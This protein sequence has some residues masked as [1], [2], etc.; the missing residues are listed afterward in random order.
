V[1]VRHN[2]QV[3]L[4][5]LAAAVTGACRGAPRSPFATA[6]SLRLERRS[7]QAVELYRALRD[8]FARTRDTGSLWQ[9]ERYYGDQ[10][11]RLGKDDSA[12][13]SFARALALAGSD[14][15]RQG[16]THVTIEIFLDRKGRLDTA[17]V[18]A[19]RAMGLARAAHDRALEASAYNSLGRIYSYSGRYGDALLANDS[20]LALRRETHAA[21]FGIANALNEL[22]IDYRHLGRYEDAEQV[23]REALATYRRLKNPGQQALVLGNLSNILEATGDLDGSLAA[24]LESMA[25]SDSIRDMRGQ[26]LAR[27]NLA[28]MYAAMGE[29]AKARDYAVQALAVNRAG[30][31]AYGTIISLQNLGGVELALGKPRAAADTERVGLRLADSLGFARERA[32][33]RAGLARALAALGDGRA[34]LR[35]ADEAV[36]LAD[37]LADPEIQYEARAAKSVAARAA[38]LSSRAIAAP[39][40]EAIALLESV[41]GRLALGDLRMGVLEPRREVYEAAIRTMVEDHRPVDAFA[42]AERARARLL[43][44][45]MSEREAA[46]ALRSREDTLR[47]A[48]RDAYDRLGGATARQATEV[49]DEIDRLTAALAATEDAARREGPDGAVRYPTPAVAG[50]VAPLVGS[51]SALLTFF[52]GDSAVYGW[53]IDAHGARAARL[54]SADSLGALV[55]FLRSAI[56]RADSGLDWRLA[57]VHAYQRLIAPL[58]PAAPGTLYVV[59][60]G[61]LAYIPLEVL[62]PAVDSAPWGATRRIVYG[63]SAGVLLALSRRSAPPA[64]PRAVL[65]VGNPA[66]PGLAGPSGATRG[67]VGGASALA[68]LPYA[69]LEARTVYDMFKSDA[70]DL[71]LGRRATRDGWLE[72]EPGR[73]RYLHFAT[74]ARIDERRPDRTA[75]AL[76]DQPLD[77]AAIRRTHLNAALVTL[78]GCETALGRRVRGEGVVGL[79]HAFLAAGARGAVVTLWRIGDRSAADFMED[80]Y[81]ALRAGRRPADALTAVRRAWI[82]K[83]GAA[84]HP[85]QWAPFILI[86][87]SE[88]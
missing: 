50:D 73:Y 33:I 57:A 6:D 66:G 16:W 76:A 88:P 18:E 67:G 13:A 71:L 19:H 1:T 84:S 82:A 9:A 65:A 43:I 27:N 80:F 49:V 34:A 61:P 2:V 8:S 3:G 39:S 54:G 51:G 72:L 46:R 53:W 21:A 38:R 69:E 29:W 62:V 15:D 30:H 25:L 87:G 55:Q 52:W 64:W 83:A 41:R 48:L 44:E 56:E 35:R 86:G 42:I 40:L 63:P 81:R 45:L 36:N 74:H 12:Q 31:L 28:A 20:E 79:P 5:L 85:S 60:D 17:L 7:T 58:A 75:L 47:A 77:L 59:P 23:F 4:T 70:S 37:S 68:P 22:G 14:P 24:R 10:L 78:S 11:G 32:M 26:G